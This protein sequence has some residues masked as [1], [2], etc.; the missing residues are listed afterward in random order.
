MKK[1]YSKFGVVFVWAVYIT[2]F[3]LMYLCIGYTIIN[4]FGME[5]NA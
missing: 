5:V 1:P 3:I 2:F 4:L